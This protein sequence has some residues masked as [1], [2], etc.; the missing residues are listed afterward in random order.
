MDLNDGS[1][2]AIPVTSALPADSDL[3]GDIMANNKAQN[4]DLSIDDIGSAEFQMLCRQ[5]VKSRENAKPKNLLRKIK[6]PT[7]PYRDRK[8]Q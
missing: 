7:F 4:L 1:A 6:R 3:L 2:N 5:F 8:L